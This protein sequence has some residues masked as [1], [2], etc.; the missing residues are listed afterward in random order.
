MRLYNLHGELVKSIQTKSRNWPYD[1]AVTSI[2]DLVYTDRVDRT[3]NIV[4][5]TD[6]QTVI[7]LQGW[8]PRNICCT[9]SGDLLVV[10]VC[11]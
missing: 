5:N 10:M 8:E 1:I 7:R 9:S 11:E 6:I 4:K 2:G 3:V